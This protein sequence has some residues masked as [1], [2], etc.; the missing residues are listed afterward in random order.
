MLLQRTRSSAHILGGGSMPSRRVAVDDDS[1]GS[2][3][4]TA[5]GIHR[6]RSI[7]HTVQRTSSGFVGAIRT[8]F[9]RKPPV[10]PST[11][12]NIFCSDVIVSTEH[13]LARMQKVQTTPTIVQLELEDLLEREDQTMFLH[14]R[15]VLIADPK[16]NVRPWSYVRFVDH[17]HSSERLDRYLGLQRDLWRLIHLDAYERHITIQF[18]CILEIQRGIPYSQL[19]SQLEM[20]MDSDA[21]VEEGKQLHGVEFDGALF[22]F[23]PW[24]VPREIFSL[25]RN[26]YL[27]ESIML[28]I[29]YHGASG[30]QATTTTTSTGTPTNTSSAGSVSDKG[31]DDNNNNTTDEATS[32][33]FVTLTKNKQRSIRVLQAC[34]VRLQGM[35]E[36]DGDDE[37]TA[38]PTETPEEILEPDIDEGK[39]DDDDDDDA[40]IISDSDDEEFA[41]THNNNNNNTPQP[42]RKVE[43]SRSTGHVSKTPSRKSDVRWQVAAKPAIQGY[44]SRQ[45]LNAMR[46]GMR[47]MIHQRDSHNQGNN[48]DSLGRHSSHDMGRR[49][50]RDSFLMDNSNNSAPQARISAPAHLMRTRSTPRRSSSASTAL[51]ASLMQTDWEREL[52]GELDDDSFR[53]CVSMGGGSRPSLGGSS[54]RSMMNGSSRSMMDGSMPRTRVSAPSPL[55]RYSSMGGSRPSLGGSGRST[56]DGSMQRSNNNTTHSFSPPRVRR[57]SSASTAVRAASSMIQS[58]DWEHDLDRNSAHS[59]GNSSHGSRAAPAHIVRRPPKFPPPLRK[60]ARCSST[61]T[62]DDHQ[63]AGKEELDGSSRHMS[64]SYSATRTRLSGPTNAMRKPPTLP[65]LSPL[66]HRSRIRRTT[67]A[68]S[69]RAAAPSTSDFEQEV[70]SLLA[71]KEN[72]YANDR[73]KMESSKAVFSSA[74]DASSVPPRR[75]QRRGS[76]SRSPK[77]SPNPPRQVQR[78]SSIGNNN[79][80]RSPKR[81]PNPPR[82][83]QRSS[84]MGHGL[85]SPAARKKI[86]RSSSMGAGLKRGAISSTSSDVNSSSQRGSQKK[87][88]TPANVPVKRSLRR[89]NSMGHPS[90]SPSKPKR[91][92]SFSESKPSHTTPISRNLTPQRIN[93]RMRKS[94]SVDESFSSRFGNA[95]AKRESLAITPVS[96]TQSPKRSI[97]GGRPK[98][99]RSST[100]GDECVAKLTMLCDD[101]QPRPSR[102]STKVDSSNMPQTEMVEFLDNVIT[103]LKYDSPEIEPDFGASESSF[104][105]VDWIDLENRIKPKTPPK[106]SDAD[107]DSCEDAD[108]E[109]LSTQ[110]NADVKPNADAD[111]SAAVWG[112]ASTSSLLDDDDDDDDD[113][114]TNPTTE[115]L[116]DWAMQQEEDSSCDTDSRPSVGS[117]DWNAIDSDSSESEC[118]FSLEEPLPESS[119]PS[120][121]RRDLHRAKSLSRLDRRRPEDMQERR[122]VRR[123]RSSNLRGLTARSASYNWSRHNSDPSDLEQS[124]VQEDPVPDLKPAPP[125]TPEVATSLDPALK[126]SPHEMPEETGT[127]SGMDK[128]LQEE[129]MEQ[130]RQ[131][132]KR[133]KKVGKSCSDFFKKPAS[134]ALYDWSLHKPDSLDDENNVYSSDSEQSFAQEDTVPDSEPAPPERPSMARTKSMPG[135]DR[136]FELGMDDRRQQMKST[137]KVGKSCS[138]LLAMEGG[139]SRRR[140]RQDRNAETLPLPMT[141]PLNPEN[142]C[143]RSFTTTAVPDY[144]W[145]TRRQSFNW[146]VYAS[147]SDAVQLET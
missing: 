5:T 114:F 115:C 76:R 126:P 57:C 22:G 32:E 121:P 141:G 11:S 90:A 47:R 103:G 119:V 35:A 7:R 29:M 45:K 37:F 21:A 56:M 53:S 142:F 111:P 41:G 69:F 58:P 97:V 117:C 74:P 79:S 110:L 65:A 82:Q 20:I 122:E 135:V 99:R 50:R 71:E 139:K 14:A 12:L 146:A 98:L 107:E 31:R 95:L 77:R 52:M 51:G 62:L 137:K 91:R 85:K 48:E 55:Q 19:I 64:R 112:T 140:R 17:V 118:S 81:N 113:G 54:G 93:R 88:E 124:F 129:Y 84:S 60:G 147:E 46:Q 67:S 18:Q 92:G 59:M 61:G 130:R 1:G 136:R 36:E 2:S 44:T 106:V 109:S 70:L 78:S 9:W 80:A 127:L 104:Q 38:S 63:P 23:V 27:R 125:E 28:R 43:R 83:V 131:Q 15:D 16:H 132:M 75:V 42:P 30:N 49:S 3:N 26:G 143:R 24:D 66:P 40:S 138:N 87:S 102:S 89:A 101:G 100:M 6:K 116:L 39:G 144:D 86:Q 8:A 133:T 145:V 120:A 72:N 123:T 33:T 94:K 128:R 68:G 25:C 4:H 134:K 96:R 105:L 108:E 13:T 10:E 34:I 73:A